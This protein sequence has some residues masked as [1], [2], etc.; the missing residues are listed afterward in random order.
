MGVYSVSDMLLS[1]PRTYVQY[2]AL[3]ESGLIE[4]GQFCAVAAHSA[5][6]VSVRRSG[7]LTITSCNVTDGWITFLMTWF[8]SPFIAK[9]LKEPNEYVFYGKVI[10]KGGRFAMEQ[11]K[12][13]RVSEYE[14]RRQSLQPV[15]HLTEGLKNR[16]VVKAVASILD[17]GVSLPEIL[18]RKVLEEHGFPPQDTALRM[19]HFPQSA[20]EYE[21]ARKKLAYEEFFLFLLGIRYQKM[22]LEELPNACPISDLSGVETSVR[23][24]PYTLTD[25]QRRTLEEICADVTGETCMQRLIQGDV[26]SGKTVLAFLTMLLFARNGYQSALMAPTETLAKQHAE[27]LKAFLAQQGEC[28]DVILLTGS[29]RAPQKKQIYER[30]QESGPCLVVGTHALFQE[31][32]SFSN[33]GLVITD[34]QHRFGVRQRERLSGKGIF[35]HI[36]VMS[37]TPIP[38]SLALILYGDLDV[39]VIPELPKERRKIKNAVITPQLRRKAYQLIYKEIKAG[40]QAFIICPLVEHSDAVE[41]EDVT[42]YTQMLRETFPDDVKIGC[43][44]GRMKAQEKEQVMEDFAQNRTQLLVSTTVIEVGINV[45]N[46]T[47]MMVENAER[48]GLAQLHQIRGRVGRGTAQSYCILVN[49]SGKPEAGKRLEVLQ[50]SNDGFEIAQE[51]LRMRGP[52]EYFGERQSGEMSFRVASIYEDSALL[53][54]ASSDA[55]EVLREDPQLLSPEHAAI[56][57]RLLQYMRERERFAGI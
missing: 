18:P 45:P 17:A 23:R 33:L 1:F 42:E 55:A 57:E 27:A 48:F 40:H 13:F 38:R 24:L 36:L 41:A 46:A 5:G 22:S 25:G 19:I 34:E 50:R 6:R 20:E 26:G 4:V 49:G 2:P 28:F 39:S 21:L 29:V 8:N 35:P 56:R 31:K 44:H 11:P 14:K 16:T 12:V 47:V 10:T 52:G 54:E 43:L 15:Y 53:Q 32:V 37:A 51:D 30:L 9:L 3:T 7:R